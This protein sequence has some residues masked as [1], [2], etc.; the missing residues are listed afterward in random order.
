MDYLVFHVVNTDPVLD[1][2]AHPTQLFIQGLVADIVKIK[3]ADMVFTG[4]SGM[5]VAL[6]QCLQALPDGKILVIVDH[7]FQLIA[8]FQS[9][10]YTPRFVGSGGREAASLVA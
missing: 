8:V 7:K 10:V 4:G 3:A 9:H 5:L 2:V 1:P 6:H